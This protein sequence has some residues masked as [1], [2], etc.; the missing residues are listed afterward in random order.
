[1]DHIYPFP[2]CLSRDSFLVNETLGPHREMGDGIAIF[3]IAEWSGP[4]RLTAGPIRDLSERRNH[5]REHSMQR[6]HFLAGL[7]AA[8]IM[9][10]P[11]SAARI[12]RI[13][14]S[15]LQGRF[16][17]FVAMNAYDK[18]PKGHTYEHT[19]IRIET[20]QGV[21]GIGAGTYSLADGSYAASL[22]PLIGA[23]PLDLY[24]MDSGRVT[25]RKP[26][27]ADLLTKNRHLDA[28]LFDIIGKLEGKPAWKLIGDAGRE[29]VPVYD[30]TLYFSD[31]WFRDRGIRAV[32]EECQEAVRSG[33]KGVKIKAG[34]GDKWMPRK[35]GDDRDIAVVHAV[36]EAIGPDTLLMVDPNYGYRNQFDAACRF[37]K[38]TRDARLHFMEE[39]FPETVESYTKLRASM[40][41]AGVRTLMAAGEHMRDIRSFEPYLKPAR[42]MD[43]LQL[44][45]RQGGFLDLARLAKMAGEAG[46]V[47][48][49]HN[50]ASQIGI[51]M[52]V[53]LGM[54]MKAVPMAESDRSTCDVLLANDYRFENGA[55]TP[56]S[57]PGMAI[58]IDEDVYK[59][60]CQ[61][62]EIVVA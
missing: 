39:I 48:M 50:W 22:K 13:R 10:A 20:D 16:H 40:R 29:R 37:L 7:A 26:A 57:K 59:A 15:T 49:P 41:D 45:I 14:L 55:I 9:A 54:A 17:K 32:V 51:F 56:P 5:D 12:T 2:A 60:K 47:V 1:M 52:G 8:P 6:R 43:V 24:T 53:Q 61:P 19:L 36:R 28:P 11:K 21:E 27:F 18:T 31:V 35:E 33:Y 62:N 34:R 30:G 44:D 42:L 3:H 38:E 25:G 58:G 46:A 4:K 23:N